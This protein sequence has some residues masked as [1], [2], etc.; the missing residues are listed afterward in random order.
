MIFNEK[1]LNT[2]MNIRIH[3]K[4]G[5]TTKWQTETHETIFHCIIINMKVKLSD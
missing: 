2:K 5:C 1:H 3:F 4:N